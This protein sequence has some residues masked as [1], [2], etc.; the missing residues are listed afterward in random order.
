MQLKVFTAEW[1]GPCKALKPHLKTI[2]SKGVKVIELDVAKEAAA[3][4]EHN[5]K[6]VPTLKLFI[7]DKLLKT[8]TGSMTLSELE[9]FIEP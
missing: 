5:I 8:Y 2:A 3:V 7:E 1:C 9:E 4:A 6:A